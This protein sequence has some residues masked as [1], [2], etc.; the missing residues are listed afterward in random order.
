MPDSTRND[1]SS[2]ED[3]DSRGGLWKAIRRFFEESE[4]DL[5]LR[6]QIEEAIDEHEEEKAADPDGED[7]G[8]DLSKAELI[9]LRNLLHF[10]ENDADD[11]AI[12]RSEIIPIDAEASWDELVSQFSEHGHSR[13]P[14]YRES[15]DNPI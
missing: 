7:A 4:G 6:A 5:S 10:S 13:L 2:Q 3:V 1:D 15:L 11:V 12:P 14:V 9:M 8:G